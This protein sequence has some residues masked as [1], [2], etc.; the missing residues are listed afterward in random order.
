MQHGRA[1]VSDG[2][3]AVGRVGQAF[4]TIRDQV[5]QS[6]G[7]LARGAEGLFALAARFEVG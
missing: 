6:A 7:D 5:A 1:E 2:V 3:G 4:L